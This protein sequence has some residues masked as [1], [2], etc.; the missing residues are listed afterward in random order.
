MEELEARVSAL[1]TQLRS[2][3]QDA[4]AARVLAGGADRDVSAFGAKLDAQQR[5]LE[6]L[7]ETQIEHG[8]RLAGHDGRF[9]HVEGRFDHLEQRFDALESQMWQ[10]FTNLERGQNVMLDLLRRRNGHEGEPPAS[11]G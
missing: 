9:D 4:A 10:G 7:R 5:L 6:A 11:S 1:E 2:V 3:R 8:R